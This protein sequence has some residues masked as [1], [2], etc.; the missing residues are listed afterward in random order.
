MRYTADQ[1][2][3][4]TE[5]FFAFSSIGG[6]ISG[7]VL[8]CTKSHYLN[9]STVYGDKSFL[10]FVSEVEKAIS[11]QYG[12]CVIFE[13]GANTEES[14][15]AC[16]TN[17]AHLHIVPFS[18]SIQALASLHDPVL[19]WIDCEIDKISGL[20]NGAE[21]FFCSDKYIGSRT[22]GLIHILE[23]PQSQFF[24]KLLATV[25]G[26]TEFYDY[27]RFPFE[28]ISGE[29]TKHLKNAFAIEKTTL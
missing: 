11:K 12:S 26:L 9:L 13:H 10:E 21:Y 23:Q 22:K 4:E 29:T 27:K 28:T 16:G 8:V 15:T 2:I 17:H 18:K 14:I 5:D 1:V 6:F 3:F 24:R 7:W 19:T 25:T 20:S